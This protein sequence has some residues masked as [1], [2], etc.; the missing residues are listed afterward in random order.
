MPETMT[1]IS[2]QQ[3]VAYD[4]GPGLAPRVRTWHT[5]RS[6]RGDSPP[7]N[8][9]SRYRRRTQPPSARRSRRHR[10]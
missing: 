8:R 6:E 1:Q 2:D 5:T 9:T 10:S 7:A 4:P 3:A